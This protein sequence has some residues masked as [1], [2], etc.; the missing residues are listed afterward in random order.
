MSLKAFV[1]N[2][3]DWLEFND[4]LDQEISK[5]RLTLEVAVDDLTVKRTQGQIMALKRM[6]Q[7]RDKLN[8]P[9]A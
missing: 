8:G 4:Y 1:N 9:S 2:P 3:K 6:K 5:L 7:L